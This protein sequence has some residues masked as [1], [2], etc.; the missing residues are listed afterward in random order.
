MH[1]FLLNFCEKRFNTIQLYRTDSLEYLKTLIKKA[2]ENNF[3]IG[4]KLVRGAYHEKEIERAREKGYPSPV[5]IKKEDTDNNYNK[6]LNICIQ[7][8]DVISIC[9]GTHNEESSELL[10]KLSRKIKCY[11]NEKYLLVEN[12]V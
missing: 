1:N 8:I 12:K 2:K 7:N 4:L 6:A 5:Y 3:F 11:Y 10:I 9:A